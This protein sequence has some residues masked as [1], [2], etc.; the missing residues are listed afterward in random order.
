ML[1]SL[2]IRFSLNIGC[3]NQLAHIGGESSPASLLLYGPTAHSGVIHQLKKHS[4]IQ[5]L[6]KFAFLF[7]FLCQILHNDQ[8]KAATK[9][10]TNG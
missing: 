3:Y 8:I 6:G 1:I 5:T 4:T 2:S 9:S 7:D 10:S